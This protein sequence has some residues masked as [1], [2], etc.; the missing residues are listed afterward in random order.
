M[1]QVTTLVADGVQIALETLSV[2]GEMQEA[3]LGPIALETH[4]GQANF[5]VDP[6]DLN[7]F[8]NTFC[9]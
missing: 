5:P 1:E 4:S 8:G 9:N 2:L 3:E 6:A 7:Y